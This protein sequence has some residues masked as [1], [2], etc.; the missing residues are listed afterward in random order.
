ME[1]TSKP[2]FQRLA[3]GLGHT[4]NDLTTQLL[5]SFRLVLFMNV[6]GLSAENAGWLVLQ[7]QLVHVVMAPVC[8][9]LVDR[10]YIPLV[11]RKYGRKKSWHLIGTFLQTVFI[12]LFFAAHY[13]IQNDN[14]QTEQMMLIYFGI[15]NVI[16]GFGDSMLDIS[17]LS[18]ISV[19][20]KD[21]IEAVELSALRFV[22]EVSIIYGNQNDRNIDI[23]L[24]QQ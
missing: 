8:A 3:C 17:H 14:G 16:L 20:A 13:L 24:M 23:V 12:P 22:H 7:K 15:L 5:F 21:Q 6:L 19:V 1:E 18:L 11:S 9:V 2:V 10:V 4:L